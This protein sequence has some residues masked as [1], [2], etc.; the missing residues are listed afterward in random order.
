MKLLTIC[1]TELCALSKLLKSISLPAFFA[2]LLFMTAPPANADRTDIEID[3]R[4]RY[5]QI[6]GF[7]TCLVSWQEPMRQ[8]YR[9]E[10]FQRFYAEE[11]GFNFLR[12][13]VRYSLLPDPVEDWRDISW[14]DFDKHAERDRSYIFIDFARGLKEYNPEIRVISSVWSGPAW[15]KVNEFYSGQHGI[16]GSINANT[17]Y[18][19]RGGDGSKSVRNRLHPDYYQHFAKWLVEWVRLFEHE[20]GIRIYAV[21]FANEPMFS[22]TFGSCV[23]NAE[24]YA[25]MTRILG[26]MLAEHDLEDVKIFGPETMT[27]HNREWGNASY[28]RELMGDPE[29]AQHFDIFATHGY[30]DGVQA[31]FGQT[32]LVQFRDMIAPY[33]RP[34]WIT[35]GGTGG[36]DWPRPINGIAAAVHN[37]FVHGGVSAFVPW[38]ITDRSANTHGMM[39]NDQ[40]TKKTYAMQHYSRFIDEGAYRIKA[41]PAEGE[42]RVSAYFHPWTGA[43]T[44]VIINPTE[45]EQDVLLRFEHTAP[46][47]EL[48]LYRTSAEENLELIDSVMIDDGRGAAFIMP[49]QSIVTLTNR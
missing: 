40:P 38:Q 8:L 26:E 2:A 18:E 15:M 23:W 24:D 29:V 36:H 13:N 4:H 30:T 45:T 42:V 33:K 3:L 22:Q 41:S 49:P 7:G 48:D 9:T 44:I 39:V 28:I 47:D 12:T 35:E 43:L 1:G 17:D 37:S 10:E 14:E 6:E 31:D 21:S 27:G 5:Q 19:H 25:K 32:R 46:V 11:M 34:F 20:T 16:T